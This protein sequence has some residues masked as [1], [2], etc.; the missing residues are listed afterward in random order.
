MRCAAIILA[1]GK[2]SRMNSNT[3]KQYME[4][5]GFPILYYSLQTFEQSALVDEIVLVT[6]EQEIEYCTKQ[7]VERYQ[8]HKVTKI[9][10]GGSERYLSVYEGLRA[11]QDTDIVLIHDGARPFVTEDMI[12][13]TIESAGA[14][15]SGITAVPAKDTVKIVNGE[16]FSMET[17]PRERVWMMQ[18]PQT[19]P[20]ETI[21]RAYEKVIAQRIKNIT[22]DAMVLELA[23]HKPVRIVEG[24]YSNIKITTPED[25]D[26][27]A[28]FCKKRNKKFEKGY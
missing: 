11:V 23:F 26:L 28:I 18:T 3:Q 1:A 17:P 5:E 6:G 27:A 13:R 4:L 25:L 16:L 20:Y 14:C 9:V 7:I 8:F 24:S 10:P 22:D 15:G 2:G 12:E 21:L 19:F